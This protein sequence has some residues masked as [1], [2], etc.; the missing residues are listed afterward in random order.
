MLKKYST[1][2]VLLHPSIISKMKIG[3]GWVLS[4]I[5]KQSKAL[6]EKLGTRYQFPKTTGVRINILSLIV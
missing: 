2:D 1:K 4:E 5:P 3:D 6:K